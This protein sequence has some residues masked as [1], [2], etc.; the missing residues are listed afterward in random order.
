MELRE[1]FRELWGRSEC[2]LASTSL[3]YETSDGKPDSFGTGI[4]FAHRGCYFVVTAAH[5]LT[6]LNNRMLYIGTDQL[7]SM[8]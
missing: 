6:A 3:I 2:W 8:T 7:L 4:F 1:A 5:V